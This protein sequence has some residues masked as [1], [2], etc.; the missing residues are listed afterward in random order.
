MHAVGRDF[1]NMPQ[2][3]TFRKEIRTYFLFYFIKFDENVI[4]QAISTSLF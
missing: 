4:S 1:R 2:F 3:D